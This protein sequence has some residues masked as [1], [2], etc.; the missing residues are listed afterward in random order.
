MRWAHA[1]ELL[2][3]RSRS[4]A[5]ARSGEKLSIRQQ[6]ATHKA[7]SIHCGDDSGQYDA[8]CQTRIATNISVGYYASATLDISAGACGLT[9]D[10]M[11]PNVIKL[12]SIIMRLPLRA[13]GEHSAWYEGTVD[14]YAAQSPR[15][16]RSM[17]N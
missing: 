14:V 16:H 9:H 8:S 13:A 4:Y 15:Q 2:I 7:K 1:I 12:P 5:H 6:L 3:Q 10:I 11:M 17:M